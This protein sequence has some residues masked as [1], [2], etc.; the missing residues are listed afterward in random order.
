VASQLGT[1]QPDK[2]VAGSGSFKDIYSAADTMIKA[3]AGQ[4]RKRM[5]M[6]T[7]KNQMSGQHY[8]GED[9]CKNQNPMTLTEDP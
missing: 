7:V 6:S 8:T 5:K 9:T 2:A 4:N 3:R 1:V